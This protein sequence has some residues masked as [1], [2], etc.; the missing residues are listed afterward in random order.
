MEAQAAAMPL[1]SVTFIVV[2][3]MDT[4]LFP[5]MQCIIIVNKMSN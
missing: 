5:T 1:I 3:C 2:S 4:V